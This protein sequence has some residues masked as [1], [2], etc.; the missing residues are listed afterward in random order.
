MSLSF[1]FIKNKG[2]FSLDVAAQTD[3][4]ITG[5]FGPS[6]CGKTTLLHLIAGIEAPDSGWLRAG[7]ETLFDAK[8]GIDVATHRRGIA[9]VFQDGRLFPH[10]TVAENLRFGQPPPAQRRFAF[11][12]IVSL[13]ELGPLLAKRPWRLS[14][15]EGQRAALGRAILQCPRVLLLDEP[16]AS[17]D[18]GLKR[19][20]LPFLR[21]IRRET[22][23]PMLQ[24]SHDLA[25][26]LQLTDR[27]LVMDRGR[28]VGHGR[29][30]DL[31]RQEAVLDHIHDLGL[32]NVLPLKISAHNHAE[33][34]TILRAGN[35]DPAERGCDWIGPP[36]QAT[37]GSMIHVALRPE[38][39]ALVK[40]P[41]ADI[42]I[43][44]QIRGVVEDIILSHHRAFCILDTG[45][46]LL[47]EI[48]PDAIHG[49]GLKKGQPL[50]CL[51]KAHAL[52]YLD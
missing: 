32:I 37:V 43:R 5:V 39:I 14:G 15:G 18:Q 16:L 9:V 19:R 50:W 28:I 24:V 11:K 34:I 33:G 17:L 2:A 38:D 42:S 35:A 47:A 12:D 49:M 1:S 51:F 40:K 3:E 26:L 10:M 46:K 30:L 4:G 8:S 36:H 21:E 7:D 22:G 44:N 45:A 41:V 31:I 23:L 48:T 25:E 20:I 27:L 13:L 29:F 6:G 52:R